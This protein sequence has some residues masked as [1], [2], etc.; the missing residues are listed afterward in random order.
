[1]LELFEQKI[2]Y[3]KKIFWVLTLIKELW[4]MGNTQHTKECAK[5]ELPK[6]FISM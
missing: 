6:K 1:M 4:N 3:A 5:L 2:K